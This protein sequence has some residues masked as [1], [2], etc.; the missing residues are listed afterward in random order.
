[1]RH[2]SSLQ[3]ARGP[4]S[5][6]GRSEI[7]GTS[8]HGGLARPRPRLGAVAS[9]LPVP[10]SHKPQHMLCVSIGMKLHQGHF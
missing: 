4:S 1:M 3:S 10:G 6:A 2:H 9:P 7:Q 5:S 8:E